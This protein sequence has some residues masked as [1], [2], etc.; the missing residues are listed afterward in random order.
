MKSQNSIITIKNLKKS[1]RDTVVLK[2][3]D[4][5]VERGS[6]FAL[7]GSNG[8]GK[9]TTIKIL[10]TLIKPDSGTAYLAG[11]SVCKQPKKVRRIISLTGQNIAIDELLTGREN[12]FMIGKLRGVR[13]LNNRI[14]TLLKQF[15]LEEAADRRV[16]TYSGGMKRKI[17]IAMS[18]LGE[19]EILF[20]D[21]PTTGLDPQSR[22]MMWQLIKKLS[23]SG[24]TIFLTT[25][26]LY[27]A[28][29]LANK[30]SILHDGKIIAEGSSD[31]LKCIIP[32][33]ILELYLDSDES[34][35]RVRDLFTSYGARVINSGR[36][37]RL[38]TGSDVG[39]FRDIFEK[40]EQTDIPIID[41]EKKKASLE[42]VFL[43][44]VG[45]SI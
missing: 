41:F 25:Q 7:L 11:Y 24:V 39:V 37:V 34:A 42:D 4:L 17:D 26:Y 5:S 1:Y 31:E 13:S 28:E 45:E 32:G 2:G 44:I 33:N 38:E 14:D 40:L 35:I 23:H 20:L 3:V 10:S 30:I 27:E 16:S 43:K 19:P 29:N 12:L 15:D 21:E 6:I 18:L 9:T 22:K 8:A 36:V